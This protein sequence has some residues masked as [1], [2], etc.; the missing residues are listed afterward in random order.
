MK[1][2]RQC[3]GVLWKVSRPTLAW[4]PSQVR[5]NVIK[6]R[7]LV[8]RLHCVTTNSLQLD[9]C[10]PLWLACFRHKHTTVQYPHDHVHAIHTVGTH[11]HVY[12]TPSDS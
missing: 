3:P 9:I 6:T 11:I 7:F 1:S 2:V 10:T 12:V 4:W 8:Q 5:L